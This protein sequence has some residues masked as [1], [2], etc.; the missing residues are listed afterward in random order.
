MS[1]VYFLK[2]QDMTKAKSK[3]VLTDGTRLHNEFKKRIL[4]SHSIIFDLLK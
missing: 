3:M 2:E 1:L 4:S